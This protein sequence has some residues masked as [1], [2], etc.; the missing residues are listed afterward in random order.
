M[1]GTQDFVI[2]GVITRSPDD[3]RALLAHE[4]TI[5]RKGTPMNIAIIN[6]EETTTPVLTEQQRRERARTLAIWAAGQLDRA[7]ALAPGVNHDGHLYNAAK[8]LEDA[9]ALLAA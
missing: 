3:A 1:S 5:E 7:N 2:D 9:S 8:A 6:L 4:T